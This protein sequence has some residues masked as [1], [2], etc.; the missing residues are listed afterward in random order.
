MSHEHL[1]QTESLPNIDIPKSRE[2]F[3][4]NPEVGVGHSFNEAVITVQLRMGQ[5]YYL[6]PTSF[7]KI[8]PSNWQSKK[9]GQALE[10][11]DKGF[12]RFVLEKQGYGKDEIEIITATE[13]DPTP[14]EP[15]GQPPPAEQ[16]QDGAGQQPFDREF[17]DI[18]AH[19]ED[20]PSVLASKEVMEHPV[21]QEFLGS[22]ALAEDV[23]VI[24]ALAEQERAEN[25]VA[26]ADL[27]AR[28]PELKALETEFAADLD[29]YLAQKY[30]SYRHKE[31]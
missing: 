11:F 26:F 14:S 7:D 8:M 29:S 28:H 30:A 23:S 31:T 15:E 2:L 18:V 5:D 25:L 13:E 24:E 6:T 16:G 27:V 22:L 17:A 21:K 4:G 12:A 10:D 3:D 9:A 1:H 19:Y 20:N